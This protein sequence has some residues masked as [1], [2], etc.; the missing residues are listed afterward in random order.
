MP[1]TGTPLGL[2]KMQDHQLTNIQT[3]PNGE[4]LS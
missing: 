1:L 2:E 4:I 3:P